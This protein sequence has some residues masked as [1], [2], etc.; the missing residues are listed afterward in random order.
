MSTSAR[1][2]LPWNWGT[3]PV[4]VHRAEDSPVRTL[5]GEMNRLF[6]DFSRGFELAPLGGFAEGGAFAPDLEVEE[7]DD[8]IRIRVELPG[9]EEK[10]VDVSLRDGQLSVRGEKREE[11]SGKEGGERWTECRYGSFVRAIPLPCEVEED[12]VEASFKRGVL[13]VTLPKTA[14]SRRANRRIEVRAG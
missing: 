12:R 2:L 1:K 10:D 5:Q 11:R 6:E 3:K 4:P 13:T 14:E 8:E 7:D 9:V